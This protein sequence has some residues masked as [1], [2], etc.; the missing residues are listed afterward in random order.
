MTSKPI[1]GAHRKQTGSTCQAPALRNGRCKMHGGK[2]T[3]PKSPE[4][5]ARIAEAQRARWQR[6]AQAL[7]YQAQQTAIG[8]ASMG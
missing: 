8:I 1:C 5:L 7:A 2:S 3:G 6:I 4:G